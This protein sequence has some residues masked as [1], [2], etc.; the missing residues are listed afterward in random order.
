MAALPSLQSLWLNHGGKGLHMFLVESQGGTAETITA[1]AKERGLTFPIP[2]GGGGFANYKGGNGLPYA[3]V[4]GPDAKVVWQG[5]SGYE[6]VI[7]NQLKRIKYP[8]LGKLEVAKEVQ[9][10][11]T[12]F[13]AGEYAKAAAAAAKVK[14]KKADD[15]EV[16]ADAE[17]VINRVN[18]KAG[19]IRAKV[20]A[21]KS[22]RRYHEAQAGLELLAG[23][24]FKGM[25]V[26]GTAAAELKEM[27]GDKGIQKEIK[28]WKDLDTVVE[29][30]AKTKD[31]PTKRTN[32]KNFIRKYEGTAAAEE[33]AKLE[34]EIAA[35]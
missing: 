29:S 8:G 28:A 6:S 14:E 31:L 25:E 34:A 21:A 18:Q 13:G 12:L 3:F 10:A 33:A 2:L 23:K 30:N 27:K 24:G 35:G 22:A 9:A 4:V 17:L 5:H 32:L 19:S 16:V 26:S 15:A 7:A 20:D 11:A 1:Y